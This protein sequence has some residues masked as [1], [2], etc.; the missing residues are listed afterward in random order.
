MPTIQHSGT[1]FTRALIPFDPLPLTDKPKEGDWIYWGHMH[2]DVAGRDNWKELARQFPT[3][4]PLRHPYLISESW[5]R[6][7]VDNEKEPWRL[8]EEWD[9]L[10]NEIDK[11]DPYYLPIDSNNRQEYLD[12]IN[13][14]LNL[15][16]RTRWTPV[17]SK[18]NTHGLSINEVEIDQE[19][20]NHIKPFIGRF[21]E[22]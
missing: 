15:N 21:Y 11:Y 16:I 20:I 12:K 14:D 3:I 8:R 17:H 7:S 5:N 13:N 22:I 9:F 6:R 2:R 4:V 1:L 19:L 10:I 18:K